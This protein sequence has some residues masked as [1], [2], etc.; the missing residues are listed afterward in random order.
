MSLYGRVQ[1]RGFPVPAAYSQSPEAVSAAALAAHGGTA[2]PA[3]GQNPWGPPPSTLRG[4]QPEGAAPPG[5]E[6]LGD[7]PGPGSPSDPDQSPGYGP[8]TFRTHAAPWPGWAGSYAPSDDLDILHANSRSIHAADF[9]GRK[10]SQFQGDASGNG[11]D[12]LPMNP[13]GTEDYGASS[14]APLSGAARVLGGLDS[15]QGYG[16]GGHGPGGVNANGFSAVKAR[17]Q[18]IT[19]NVVNAYLDPAD[20]PFYVPQGSGSYIPTDAVSG[21]EPFSSFIAADGLSY[22]A[23]SPYQ[24]SPEPETL[25]QPLPA[26]TAW[27]W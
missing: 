24:P 4:F 18:N 15:V 19:G 6:V 23:P 11:A 2:D 10:L 12:Y 3:H 8:G 26:A 21:P 1:A 13:S 9:G 17:H 7:I 25:G 5:V 20:R 14:Q 27:G 16:G 22:N